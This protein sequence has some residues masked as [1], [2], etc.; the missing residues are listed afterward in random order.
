MIDFAKLS[1]D[2]R[3]PYFQEVANQRG[4][5]R[6]IVEKDFWV[7]FTLRLLFTR[8]EFLDRFVFKGGTS[9]SKVFGIIKR[10]SEDIDLS[11]DPDWLGFGGPNRPDAASSRSQFEK[12]RKKLNRACITTVE[13]IVAPA[14]EQGIREVLGQRGLDRNYLEFQVDDQTQSPV[15]IFRYPTNQLNAEGY[16]HPQVKL[17]L[18]SLTDQWPTGEHT[19]TPWVADDFPELFSEPVCRVVALEADAPS[20]RRQP[21]FM[22]STIVRKT[23]R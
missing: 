23:G 20:G 21:S 8:P 5:I 6:L 3:D 15:I 22:L 10:F 2:E 19:V 14:L 16:I 12:R 17:E 18:G 11:V 13:T 7:C 9:L 1:P 4:L